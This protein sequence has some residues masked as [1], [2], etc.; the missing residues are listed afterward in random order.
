MRYEF[1]SHKKGGKREQKSALALDDQAK[2]R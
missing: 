2:T 1:I